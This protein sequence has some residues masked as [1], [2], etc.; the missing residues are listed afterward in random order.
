MLISGGI[1][2]SRVIKSLKKDFLRPTSNK[3]RQSIF[4]V[5][6]HKF[7]FKY[8]HTRNEMLDAFAGTG[9]VSLEAISRGLG[10]ATM[11]EKDKLIYEIMI[12]NIS[13]LNVNNL[14]TVIKKSFFEIITFKN[15]FKFIFLDPPF[16]LN[17]CNLSLEKILDEG[18]LKRDGI[19]ICETEKDF[20]F[21]SPFSNYLIQKK[22]YGK[23]Q[24]NYFFLD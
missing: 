16:Y 17:Y 23:S 18:L 13:S 14:T 19:V 8:W 5:L 9:S 11:V 21:K 1:Y 22:I 10:K 3:V 2:K 4:N 20:H 24:I 12:K 15:K 7:N 6:I